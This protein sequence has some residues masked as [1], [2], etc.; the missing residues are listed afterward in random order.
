MRIQ[1]SDVRF[2]FGI[3][4]SQPGLA[5]IPSARN[6][7]IFLIV[8]AWVTVAVARERGPRVEVVCPSPPIP[9]R[10]DNKEVLA[11]ELHVTNFDVARLTL[12]R[13]EVFAN[14]ESSR[15]VSSLADDTLTTA[16]IRIGSPM[17]MSGNPGGEAKVARVIEPGARSV[18]FMWI[19]LP[20]NRAVP[21]SLKH[22]MLFSAAGLDGASTT[23]AT[24]ENFQVPVSHDAAPTLDP[25]FRGG[26][27]FA[28]NGPS[29]NSDHRRTITAIDGHIHSAER[30]AID[31]IK[32]GPNGDSR[33]DGAAHNENWWGWGEPM[34]AVGME[35]LPNWW[36]EYRTTRQGCC[37]LSRWITLQEI[38]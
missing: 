28:G 25:P 38:M 10:M 11:Y 36:M 13:V 2:V 7:L 16:M 19:E 8:S 15:P 34:L 12:K 21:V 24:L 18:I 29:N 22:R 20:S 30:F 35:K 6:S 3:P 17:T 33:H 37:L 32:V 27:W 14:E 23:D 26:T 9:V 1:D 5:G 4:S 31:W